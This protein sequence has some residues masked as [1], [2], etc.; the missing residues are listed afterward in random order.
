MTLSATAATTTEDVAKYIAK[1]VAEV[2][3]AMTGLPFYAGMTVL[4]I[5][6]AFFLVGE[7]FEGLVRLFE[8]YPRPLCCQDYDP[9]DFS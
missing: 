5:T 6:R 2:G 1:S 7:Y 9:D 3:R 4:I 8:R